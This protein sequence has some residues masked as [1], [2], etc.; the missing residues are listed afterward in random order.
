VVGF[1]TCDRANDPNPNSKFARQ[2]WLRALERTAAIDRNPDPDLPVLIERWRG[3]FEA[4]PAL[5][6][7]EAR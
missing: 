3:A 1:A 5:V 4:A 7:P 6:S 2:A